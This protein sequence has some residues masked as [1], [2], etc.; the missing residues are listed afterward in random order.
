MLKIQLLTSTAKA[1]TLAHP[2]EDVAYDM[3]ADEEKVIPPNSMAMV[4]TGIAMEFSPKAGAIIK[5][6]SSVAKLQASVEAGVI[7][8]GYRGEVMVLL[9][10]HDA[11]G[12]LKIGKGE[13]FA[14]MVKVPIAT[15][16]VKVVPELKISKRGAKGF[17]SSGK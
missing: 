8:A 17:G 2:G 1:P 13:K 6:R 5:C 7:D 3:Y 15:D 9:R 14:Q 12:F 11:A 16:K 10:N 4:K